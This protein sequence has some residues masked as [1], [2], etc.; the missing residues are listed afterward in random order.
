MPNFSRPRRKLWSPKSG[1]FLWTNRQSDLKSLWPQLKMASQNSV[2]MYSIQWL[3]TS[4]SIAVKATVTNLTF[5]PHSWLVYLSLTCTYL[6]IWEFSLK[7]NKWIF[8]SMSPMKMKCLEVRKWQ[9]LHCVFPLPQLLDPRSLLISLLFI[10]HCLYPS[11]CLFISFYSFP[12][13]LTTPPFS[14][15]PHGQTQWPRLPASFDVSDVT[16]A[17]QMPPHRQ[18]YPLRESA[19][20]TERASH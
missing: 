18:S 8:E 9:T 10:F 19:Q 11:L 12:I 4:E 20:P 7:M 14:P 16:P 3:L 17:L 13:P 1:E 5:N 6:R 2:M 15:P